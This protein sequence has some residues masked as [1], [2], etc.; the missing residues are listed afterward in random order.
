MAGR[1][2]TLKVVRALIVTCAVLAAMS[3]GAQAN[4]VLSGATPATS[5]V[6]LGSQGFGNAPRLLTLQTN[7]IESGFMTPVDITNGDAIGNNGGKKAST[8]TLSTLQWNSGAAVGIGFNSDQS[9]GTGITMQDLVLTIYNGTT[10]V[11]SFSLAASLKP[12]TF[13]ST[14]LAMQQGNGNAVFDF[15]LDATEQAQFNAILAMPGSSG[16]FA[17]LG[18]T[19]G[20]TSPVSPGCLVS[21]DG[22]DSFVGFV[23]PGVVVPEPGTL[24]LAGTALL[25]VA[26]FARKKLH[27]LR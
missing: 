4:L 22:P 7:G 8:P 26:A 9:G 14:D 25:G 5:F 6:D 3:S 20:C 19:L 17:G 13:S 12:L 18:S 21:N 27:L 15:K 1:V 2:A 23:Q 10:A 16:F 11:G 24:L